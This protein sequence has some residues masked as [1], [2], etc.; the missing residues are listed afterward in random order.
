VNHHHHHHRYTGSPAF[1]PHPHAHHPVP[2]GHCRSCGHPS[3][4]CGCGCRTCRK[5][6]KELLVQ[7]KVGDLN[8]SATLD[9]GN[10]FS[11]MMAEAAKPRAPGAFAAAD[12]RAAAA[13]LGTGTAFIGG[14]CC[15]HI[16]VEYTPTSPTADSLVGIVVSDS[17]GTMLAWLRQEK[18]GT[19][20]QVKEGI[21]TTK[22][23]ATI[24]VVVSNMVARVR[25]CEVFSC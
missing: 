12:T 9:T 25:W 3:G 24:T 8:S 16:S 14:G 11:A 10:V 6:A 7:A 17:E 19:H 18:A 4:Q 22:P 20:Y 5:E 21:I 1:A 23:G 13:Q 15:V 2:E